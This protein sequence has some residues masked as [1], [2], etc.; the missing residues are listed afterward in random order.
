[1]SQCRYGS[2]T[3]TNTYAGCDVL[4]V[5]HCNS[6]TGPWGYSCCRWNVPTLEC[7]QKI[8]NTLSNPDECP[9]CNR[10]ADDGSHTYWGWGINED[11]GEIQQDIYVEGAVA[12]QVNLGCGITVPSGR[13]LYAGGILMESDDTSPNGHIYVKSGGK[14]YL[15]GYGH[16]P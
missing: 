6:D 14:I 7:R 13:T 4:D 16:V 12:T 8:C 3:G 1:M 5:A 2:I 10:C 15:Y 11:R 9:G